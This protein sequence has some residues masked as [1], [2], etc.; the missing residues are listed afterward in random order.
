MLTEQEKF[1]IALYKT[2][3]LTIVRYAMSKLKKED[4][5]QEILQDTFMEATQQVE[6]LMTHPQPKLWLKKTAKNKIHN[7]ERSQRRYLHRV[8]SMDSDVLAAIADPRQVEMSEV[9]SENTGVT[10]IEKTIEQTLT[11]EE[12]TFSRRLTLEK[13]SHLEVSK[14]LGISVWASQKRLERI[15]EKLKKKF[16]DKK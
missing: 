7:F 10:E 9:V 5:A 1:L 11:P 13:A 8:L 4:L 2:Y 6:H 16:F 14:E 12:A 3:R 15:R